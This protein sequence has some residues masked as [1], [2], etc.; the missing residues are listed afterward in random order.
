MRALKHGARG[1]EISFM[2]LEFS[3]SKGW[4]MNANFDSSKH[5]RSRMQANASELIPLFCEFYMFIAF[6]TDARAHANFLR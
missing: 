5:R 2:W 6:Y 1:R 3:I 4:A